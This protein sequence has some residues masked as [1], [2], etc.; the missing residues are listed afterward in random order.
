MYNHWQLAWFNG[1]MMQPHLLLTLTCISWIV[2]ILWHGKDVFCLHFN[3]GKCWNMEQ[4]HTLPPTICPNMRQK[5]APRNVCSRSKDVSCQR[6]SHFG[7]RECIQ[8]LAY[9][10][11][12]SHHKIENHISKL[13]NVLAEHM[14]AQKCGNS[15]GMRADAGGRD[16]RDRM[17]QFCHRSQFPGLKK[18]WRERP[19]PRVMGNN[20]RDGDSGNA[21]VCGDEDMPC[22]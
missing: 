12:I 22:S 13:R 2:D 17:L 19:S 18:G 5:S 10:I 15:Y 8:V 20:G 4:H 11:S 6:F 9:L 1:N 7:K 21:L 14:A 3:R 16:F